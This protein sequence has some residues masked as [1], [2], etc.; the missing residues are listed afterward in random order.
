[1]LKSTIMVLKKEPY[2]EGP[3]EDASN[4]K[5]IRGCHGTALNYDSNRNGM[6]SPFITSALGKLRQENHELEANI[7]YIERPWREGY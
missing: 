5:T 4:F 6:V 3:T 1:M 7:S 2:I